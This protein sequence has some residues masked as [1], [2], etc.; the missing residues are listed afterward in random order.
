MNKPQISKRAES[1]PD[2]P[3]RKLTPLADA[4]KKRGI[5][6]YHLNI[7]QPDFN[8]PP[9]V[10]KE[11]KK[12]ADLDYLPYTNSRGTNELILA[13]Q[14]YYSD[15]GVK[16]DESCINITTGGSEA[17]VMAI[18]AVT[19]AGD[20]II[21]FEPYYANY[22]G[23]A[24]LIAVKVVPVALDAKCGYHLR[25]E[26]DIEAKIT[27]KTRA[28]VF[29]NPNNPTGTVFTAD[30]I[31]LILKIAKKYNLFIIA[32]ETYYGLTFDGRKSYS[33]LN[34]A[35]DK[36][37]DR[38]I[39]TDSVS[40]RFN[41]C[42]ARIGA[43]ISPNKEVMRVVV[44]FAQERLSVATIDQQIVVSQ[45]KNSLPYTYK[46]AREY[47]KRRDA[48]IN[49]LLDK[50]KLDICQPEGA[51]YTMLPLP[52]DDADKFASWMLTDFDLGGETV[53]VAPGAGFYGTPGLGKREIRVAYVLKEDDLKKAAV[54]LAAA[55]KKY[56]NKD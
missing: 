53:M 43:L 40:K 14:K 33:V 36:E 22:N 35:G 11:M 45:V 47:Q 3:I 50:I 41:M 17:L 28:L 51:F 31:K 44:R 32:D 7:G 29:T 12:L 23:F 52:V 24:N 2:S 1:A 30:E 37:R 8:V 25:S 20:E 38:V 5:K 18:A 56:Q 54:I 39:I 27:N 19:D 21:A 4:A 42:G 49:T 34:F 9:L 16:V 15:I 46:I 48:F 6:V 13:W 26:G 55:I 10:A